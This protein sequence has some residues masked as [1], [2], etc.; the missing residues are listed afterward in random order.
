MKLFIPEIGDELTLVQDWHFETICEH[1]NDSLFEASEVPPEQRWE[2]L[3]DR[4]RWNHYRDG[5]DHYRPLRANFVLPKDTVLKVD[6]VYI[7]KG[8][9]D[10]SSITF[11]IVNGPDK[12][13][14]SKKNKGLAPKAVRFWVKLQETRN[15]EIEG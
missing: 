7:R 6:R 4:S 3:S 14:V 15:I 1:R 8:N 9:E 5:Y 11:I 10:F 13:V 2:K 12:R